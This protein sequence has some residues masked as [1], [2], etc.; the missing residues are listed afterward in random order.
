M[1][2]LLLSLFLF[3]IT[4]GWMYMNYRVNIKKET[5]ANKRYYIRR[6]YILNATTS[7]FG[8]VGLWYFITH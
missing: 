7:G 2:E 5:S 3:I 6:A 1:K 8:V 4:Q